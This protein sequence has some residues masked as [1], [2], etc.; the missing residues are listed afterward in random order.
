MTCLEHIGQL[1]HSRR[2]RFCRC[3]WR[4]GATVAHHVADRGIG[5]MPNARH[6]R[7]GTG[8][9]RAGKLLVVKGH[10][11][12]EGTA[13]T[14]EQNAIGRRCNGSGAAQA[15]NKLCRCTLALDLCAHAGKLDERVATAQR[16]LDV[17]DY[18]AR[19]R[20]DNRHARAKHRDA[21]LAR[22][23]HQALTA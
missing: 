5:L 2:H 19:K 12:L 9:H 21:A 11:V 20:G 1:R 16:T 23:V 15:F 8:C 14:H 3:R 7:H 4:G 17:V 13:A 18:G 22:F 6:H 10:E